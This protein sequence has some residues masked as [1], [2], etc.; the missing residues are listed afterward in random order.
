MIKTESVTIIV[1]TGMSKY[2]ITLSPEVELT[3]NALLLYPYIMNKTI[4]HGQAA[5]IL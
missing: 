5:E 4:S 1:P 2:L 3:R